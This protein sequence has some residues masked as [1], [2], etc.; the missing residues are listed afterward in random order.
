MD[1]KTRAET[2]ASLTQALRSAYVFP[3]VGDAVAKML[4]ERHAR[5]EYD[6]ITSAKAFSDVLTKQMSEV[7]HDQHLS[8][9]YSAGVLPPMPVSKGGEPPPSPC[10]TCEL[11]QARASN[12]GFESVERLNGNVGYLKFVN[13]TGAD[14]G[15]AVAAGAMA[16]LANTNALIIDLRDN[17]GGGPSIFELLT[18]YFF[19]SPVHV[20]DFAFRIAGRRDYKVTQTWTLPAVPWPRYVDKEVY[21]LTSPR[22]FSVAE[23][24]TDALHTQKRATV[25]GEITGGGANGGGPY[26]LGDHFF[27]SMP[28]AYFENPV[29]KSNWEGQ[30]ITPDVKVPERDALSTAQRLALQHLIDKTTDQQTL[31]ALKQALAALDANR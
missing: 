12:Y 3:D 14:G 21:I 16:L 10:A 13:F 7:A 15:D 17:H 31:R 6:A 22:T 29:T 5:G 30:G 28:M 20:M 25:V 4:E 18:S 24:F 27:A 11:R 26:R 9:D 1:A 19:T 2:M 23:A 8:V